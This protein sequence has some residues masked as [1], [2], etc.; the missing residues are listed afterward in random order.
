MRLV[1]YV[2]GLSWRIGG[3]VGVGV[4]HVRCVR[5]LGHSSESI[6]GGRVLLRCGRSI[7]KP[8]VDWTWSGHLRE[9]P[10]VGGQTRKSA[11]E[12]GAK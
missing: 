3:E 2:V 11:T 12:E 6:N 4:S 7:L 8:G 1:G 10:R 9:C 5:L